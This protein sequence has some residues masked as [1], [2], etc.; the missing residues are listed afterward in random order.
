MSL[1]TEN[2]QILTNYS[3]RIDK[4]TASKKDLAA[5]EALKADFLRQSETGYYNQK[6]R[7]ILTAIASAEL[8]EMREIIAINEEVKQI[9]RE[10]SADR[11]RE[12]AARKADFITAYCYSYG[13]TK[14]HAET[15]YKNIVVKEGNTNYLNLII[16]GYKQDAARAAF[17]D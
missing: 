15:V 17:N 13:S 1:F 12:T 11:R 3:K 6:H 16:E 5:L 7:D 14:K 10:I 9:S 4:A 8:D 2:L